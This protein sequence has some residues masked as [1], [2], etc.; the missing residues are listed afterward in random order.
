MDDNIEGY[1]ITINVNYFENMT[2]DYP[3]NSTVSK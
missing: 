2:E 1:N 3:N